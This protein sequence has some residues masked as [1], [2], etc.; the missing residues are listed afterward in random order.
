MKAMFANEY[1]FRIILQHVQDLQDL[2]SH[3]RV[4]KSKHFL[5]KEELLIEVCP[6]FARVA[7]SQR[8]PAAIP[9]MPVGVTHGRGCL[10]HPGFYQRAFSGLP[11]PDLACALVVPW[12]YV[13]WT[14]GVPWA[15]L[16]CTLGVPWVVY[17][18]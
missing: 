10:M 15:Y 1:S 8:V 6:S 3:L 13:G 5:R 9:L 11:T 14:L 4:K 7:L 2:Q 16:G 18:G 12:A 17:L